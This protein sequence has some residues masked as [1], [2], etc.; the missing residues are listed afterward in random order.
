MERNTR[1]YVT[2]G[3]L[4]ALGYVSLFFIR[5]PIIP[6]ASFLRFDVKDVFISI[7]G[8]IFG[9]LYAL[10]GAVA[11]SFLQ[12]LSVSEYGIIGLIMN[13]VSVSSFV[14]PQSVIYSKKKNSTGLIIGLIVGC[15]SMVIAMLLWNYLITPMY[16]GVSRDVVAK[17]ILPVFLP[18]NLIKS[19]INSIIIFLIFTPVKKKILKDV[20]KF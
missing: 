18:F 6:S 16:M 10:I 20:E 13:T 9:P 3:L 11:V 1:K 8:L 12:M 19:I 5:I 2:M 7:G 17:M 14:I 15:I 4:V